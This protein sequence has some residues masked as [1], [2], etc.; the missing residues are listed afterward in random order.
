MTDEAHRVHEARPEIQNKQWHV[1]YTNP[2]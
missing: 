2:L 1:L